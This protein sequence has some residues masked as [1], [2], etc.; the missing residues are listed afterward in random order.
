MVDS[1][2][3]VEAEAGGTARCVDQNCAVIREAALQPGGIPTGCENRIMQWFVPVVTATAFLTFCL[4]TLRHGWLAA[5]FDAMAVLLVACPCAL[6]FA[7]PV[8]IWTAMRRLN[9]FGMVVTSGKAIEKLALVN[10]VAFDKTGTL[11]L[12]DSTP[13]LHLEPGWLH[14]RALVENLISAAESAVE[15]PIAKALRP[16]AKENT[17][18]ARSVHIEPGLGIRAEV[19]SSANTR[20]SVRIVRIAG[21]SD[22][23]G[24]AL[25]WRLIISEL[26]QFSFAKPS[27]RLSLKLFANS[28]NLVSAAS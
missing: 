22:D 7:T 11:T 26:P 16:L 27:G 28:K 23:A 2:L 13:E 20:H 17:F 3:L 1:T 25:Q 6:G 15:H 10:C 18:L 5:L 4:Q 24:H 12:P 9:A 19:E 14:C 21:V 8:A